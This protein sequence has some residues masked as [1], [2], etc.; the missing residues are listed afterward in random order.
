MTTDLAK[1]S[2]AAYVARYQGPEDP[3]ANFANEGGP[4]IQGK[5]LTCRKGDWTIGQDATPV[6]A[7]T[8]FL[9]LVPEIMRGWLKWSG[10]SVIA[11]DMGFVRD[12]FL[13]KHR[14]ALGDLDEGLWEKDPDG[15]PRDPWSHSY[16]ALLT[17]TPW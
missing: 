6:P 1:Q 2:N 17:P 15:A 3:Y 8:R 7:D 13:V 11:A 9:L 10:G 4:G 12:N 14:Y 5:L 16:R